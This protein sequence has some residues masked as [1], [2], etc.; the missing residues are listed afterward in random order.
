MQISLVMLIG[1]A[2]KNAILVVEYA[3]RLF[4]EKACR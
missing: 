1:L 2:A 3:D 4:N